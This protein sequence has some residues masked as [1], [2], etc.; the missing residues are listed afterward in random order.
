MKKKKR[1]LFTKN[2]DIIIQELSSHKILT[3]EQLSNYLDKFKESKLVTKNLYYSKFLLKLID[4][5]LQQH[6][7][8]IKGVSKTRYTFKT[9]LDQYAFVNSF[10]KYGF[11]SMST[12]LN[13]QDYTNFNN[14]FIFYS[15]EQ[16]AKNYYNKLENLSQKSIDNAFSKAYRYTHKRV[17]Y[18][19]K[20]IVILNPKHTNEVGVIDFKEYRVSSINRVFVEMI[21]N[22]QYFKSYNTILNIFQP[23][24]DKLN[25][26]EI[27]H[28][29]KEF[30]FIYPYFQLFGFTL[31][32]L[33]FKKN[34]LTKF[35]NEI[36][37]LKFYTQK[38]LEKYN[39]DNYW[40]IYY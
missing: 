9:D 10:E 40:N 18:M 12:A 22:L 19:D 11:F 36:E 8:L 7:V 24:K 34:E 30:E 13:I 38:N 25:I 2:K 23:L 29:I 17:K 20:S 27:F 21:V 15:N 5:G 14:N 26:D 6:T 32:K 33:G 1:D 31:E 39:L 4:L 28:I 35:S 16:Q 37:K 3:S